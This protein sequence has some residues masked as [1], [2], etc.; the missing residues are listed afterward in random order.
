MKKIQNKLL[1]TICSILTFCSVFASNGNVDQDSVKVSKTNQ[2]EYVPY[3]IQERDQVSAAI[4]S[5]SG[6]ELRTIPTSN[7]F[8]AL[9]GRIP[10][11]SIVQLCGEAGGTT[12]L[13]VDIRGKD[14]DK[15]NKIL[16]I[17]DGVERE[18]A[19]VDIHDIERV[20]LLKDAAAVALYG[21]RGSNGVLM[22][23][24]KTGFDGKSKI[25][26]SVNHAF[27]TP[28]RM[29]EMV[30]AYDYV[31]MHNQRVVND[32]RALGEEVPKGLLYSDYEIERYKLGDSQEF[33]P[34]RDVIK[35][36]TKDF[37]QTTRAN[38]NFT[39]GNQQVKYFAS[40]GFLTQDGIFETQDFDEYYYNNQERTNR[41]NFRTN[42]DI[43]LNPTLVFK[44]NIGG[45]LQSYN[46]PYIKK[47]ESWGYLIGK[48]Y[49][50]PN[51]AF[52]DL[53]PGGE[54]LTKQNRLGFR[55]KESVYAYLNRTG[56][57][58]ESSTRLG[59]TFTLE[60][61]LSNITPGLKATGQLSFD[62]FSNSIAN[63]S[64]SY[65]AWEVAALPGAGGIDSLGYVQIDGT[66]NSGLSDKQGKFFSYMYNFRG[67]IDY[68]RKFDKHDVTALV[69]FERQLN[70]QQ[71]YLSTNYLN[72][73]GRVAYSYDKRYALEVNASYQGSEQ[74]APG[75]RWGL[76]PS[77]SGAWII[78]NENFMKD[79][80]VF[81]YLKLRSSFGVIGNSVYNYGGANQYLYL[82]TWHQNSNED[83]LGNMDITWEKS[84]KTNIGLDAQL[85]NALTLS[86]D[87]YYNKNTDIII[88]KIATAPGGF[89]GLDK[90]SGITP[91]R[92]L[93]E[94]E[95]KG[96]ELF[97]SYNK[98][99][100]N[101]L[102]FT[103][104]GNVAY[105]KNKQIEMGEMPYDD[106]Y[107][108]MY[109]M[110][111]YAV[112][113][114]WGY[115]TD[116]LF[117]S[118]QEIIDYGVDY[119][120]FGHNPIPGDIKYKD[121][122]EDG[123][124]NDKDKAPL[125][126]EQI[127]HINYGIQLET[128]FKG[129]DVRLFFNGMA[130]RQVY[131][132]GFGRWSN[133]DNFTEYMKGAWSE[134]N[135]SATY[136]RLGNESQNFVRSDYWMANGNL[137]RLKN[138]E[139]GYTLPEKVVKAIHASSLRLYI[140]ATNLFVTDNLPTTDFDAEMANSNGTNYPIMKDFNAGLTLKF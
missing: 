99:L 52:N 71:S 66:S 74:F 10:G 20:S 6:D 57:V 131:L 72:L 102:M 54:V 68:A 13:Y 82:T 127:P 123:V 79:N 40:M 45:Y 103:V 31:N 53:T 122:N 28:T 8:V 92:N 117:Q 87:V 98:V 56:L 47:D 27:E 29:P 88:D 70:Q 136:P 46:R 17:V 7:L 50:T 89:I 44:V 108:Y 105:N 18:V 59:N 111:G 77:V 34:T 100:N 63:R 83:Q 140:N 11:L 96:F 132:H 62:V 67:Q 126:D 26:I 128:A 114:Q 107:A 9:Q 93:G 97:A 42:L 85:F 113:E 120:I 124:I 65:E 33:Y 135:T 90:T 78:S 1:I 69:F 134:T 14:S 94:I 49:E 37:M 101:G 110:A 119:S 16:T 4:F 51:N 60:Q 15:S 109:R 139:L 116:G 130:N 35:D 55:P 84:K 30:K 76:F 3:G 64:R 86:A 125:G 58:H 91:P 39:G 19:D 12:N 81:T 104:A 61:K 106:T 48:L 133:N 80:N 121:L 115:L 38:I 2:K 32:Y 43:T 24:T 25:D 112:Q 137:F 73:A 36:F 22:V 129:F 41:F 21:M 95:N 23:T 75:K 138:A 118:E 5:I